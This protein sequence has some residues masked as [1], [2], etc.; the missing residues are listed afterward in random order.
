MDFVY[1]SKDAPS[2]QQELQMQAPHLGPAWRTKETA[3]WLLNRKIIEW[4]DIPWG[5]N[6]T[7]RLPAG[8]TKEALNK[9]V[10]AWAEVDDELA[11]RS[12]K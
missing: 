1:I 12:I 11:K 5:I 3:A 7:C 8:Y 6:C 10:Q 4:E 9:V 2:N